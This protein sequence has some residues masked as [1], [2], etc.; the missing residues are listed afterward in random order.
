MSLSK[1]LLKAER[2]YPETSSGLKRL[3]LR[4]DEI[5]DWDSYRKVEKVGK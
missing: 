4:I 1:L 2:E 5:R 3:R